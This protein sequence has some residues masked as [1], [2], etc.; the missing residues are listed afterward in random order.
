MVMSGC[1][2]SEVMQVSA[3]TAQGD[4]YAF[5]VDIADDSE[6]RMRGLQNVSQLSDDEGMWFVFDEPGV[7][8]FWMKD[9]LISLDMIFVDE[10]LKI[11]NVVHAVPPCIA[12]DPEQ[13]D[14]PLYF[15]EGD[16]QYVL[17]LRGGVAEKNGLLPGDSVKPLNF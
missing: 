7:R 15:S 17:E 12:E 14:C 9:T 13:L 5:E 8:S 11:L 4:V 10:N 3:L 6:E 2:G 1:M 16:A